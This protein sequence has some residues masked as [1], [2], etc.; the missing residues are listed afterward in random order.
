MLTV[1]MKLVAIYAPVIL[2]SLEMDKYAVCFI[3]P[4]LSQFLLSSVV[5]F[6]SN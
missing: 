4:P 2:A 1:I 3:I 5:M 6:F